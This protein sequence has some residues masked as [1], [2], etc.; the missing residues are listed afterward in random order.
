RPSSFALITCSKNA[1]ITNA[2][3]TAKS[4]SSSLAQ[5]SSNEP[6]SSSIPKIHLDDI[7][8]ASEEINIDG[9]PIDPADLPTPYPQVNALL[10]EDVKEKIRHKEWVATTVVPDTYSQSDPLV[11]SAQMTTIAQIST[12]HMLLQNPFLLP[13]NCRLLYEVPPPSAVMGNLPHNHGSAGFGSREVPFIGL[14][15][16]SQCNKL[17][18]SD[19]LATLGGIVAFA[20]LGNNIANSQLSALP[21]KATIVYERDI[22]PR[23]PTPREYFI[24]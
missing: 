4:E 20:Q 22:I 15:N 14:Y 9:E 11:N 10:Q 12:E 2:G 23:S 21:T 1:L 17:Q 19:I 6:S 18:I 3:S 16:V 7:S 24:N 13:D 8:I 5:L